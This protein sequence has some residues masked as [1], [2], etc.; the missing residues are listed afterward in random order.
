MG[1][2][3]ATGSAI[4]A[5]ASSLRSTSP[6]AHPGQRSVMRTVTVPFGPVTVTYSPQA[7]LPA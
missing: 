7:A 4:F 5:K 2:R 6:A 1:T 3:P